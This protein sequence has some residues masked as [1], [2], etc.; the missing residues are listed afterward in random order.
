MQPEPERELFFWAIL[1]NRKK[2]AKIFWKRGNDHIG[3]ALIASL[4][5][6]N[7]AAKAAQMEELQLAEDLRNNAQ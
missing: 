3:G 6:N 1:F 5:F 2:L 4:M 7:L